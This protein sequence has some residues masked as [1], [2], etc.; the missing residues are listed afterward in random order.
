LHRR[1]YGMH[2][3]KLES[4]YENTKSDKAKTTF[5][6]GYEPDTQRLASFSQIVHEG[7]VSDEEDDW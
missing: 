3:T 2:L 5:L 6:Q 7:D 1:Y 4:L